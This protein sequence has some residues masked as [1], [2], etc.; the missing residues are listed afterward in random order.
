MVETEPGGEGKASWD[1]QEYLKGLLQSALFCQE[2]Y[3]E[4]RNIQFVLCVKSYMAHS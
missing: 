3:R 2:S 1:K 4:V